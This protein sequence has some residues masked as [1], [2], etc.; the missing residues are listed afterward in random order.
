MWANSVW[1]FFG[2]SVTLG[3][4]VLGLPP[5]VAWLRPWFLIAAT[6]SFAVSII[7]LCWP[8][9]LAENRAVVY[10]NAKHPVRW[11]NNRRKIVSL[12]VLSAAIVGCFT[13]YAIWPVRPR[14]PIEPALLTK[15]KNDFPIMNLGV[16]GGFD[17]KF[18]ET[19]INT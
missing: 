16:P 10:A 15:M 14:G 9:R 6:I 3:I 7:T 17:V 13:Y 19:S 4:A 8:L 12:A 1:G 18:S 2:L 11:A 5:G